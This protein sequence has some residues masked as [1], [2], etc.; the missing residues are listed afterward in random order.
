MH[1]VASGTK[2]HG[3]VVFALE[4]FD[5]GGGAKMQA[6]EEFQEA[7]LFFVDTNNFGGVMKLQFGKKDSAFLAE[8][9]DSAAEGNSMGTRFVPREALHQ[10]GLDFRRDSVFH[11]LSFGVRFGPG[12]AD[13]FR[14]KHFR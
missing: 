14:E 10:E 12:Q 4:D 6:F 13:D 11:A 9:R 1:G 7:F 5:F 8:L 2:G 3:F